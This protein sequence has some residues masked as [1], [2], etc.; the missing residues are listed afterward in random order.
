[1]RKRI[2]QILS[3]IVLLS[4]LLF[5]GMFRQSRNVEATNITGN[6]SVNT[7]WNAAGS[8]YIM[9]EN[10]TVLNGVTLTI[11]TSGG[12]V[13][14]KAGGNFLLIINSGG[15]LNANGS[16]ASRVTFTHNTSTALGS[17]GGIQVDTGGTA[18]ILYG[19]IRYASYGVNSNGGTAVVSDSLFESNSYAGNAY[20]GGI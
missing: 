7:T 17:W 1:M 10:V 13:D 14:V 16:A 4:A 3:T 19:N 2:P 12:P 8:P 6:I 15:T 5:V 20:N 9:T 18:N 11:D